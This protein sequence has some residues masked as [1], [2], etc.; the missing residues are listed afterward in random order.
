MTVKCV[1]VKDD[2]PWENYFPKVPGHYIK[3]YAWI[4]ESHCDD[5][6][7]IEFEAWVK[8]HGCG[9]PMDLAVLFPDDKTQLL[10]ALRW[11]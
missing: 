11:L 3:E 7:V 10:F 8:K 9:M 4:V 5:P 2:I 6:D 1:L